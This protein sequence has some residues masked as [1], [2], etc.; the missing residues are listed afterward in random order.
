MIICVTAQGQDLDAAVDPRFGRCRYF[1]FVDP[2]TLKLE[3]IEND[4]VNAAGGAGV[5]SG[6]LVA[7]REARLVLTGNV[8]PNAHQTLKAAGVKIVTGVSGTVREAVARYSEGALKPTAG[9]S[10]G[11]HAGMSPGAG[12]GGD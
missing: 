9:A 12:K 3:A 6:Q 10:V 5:R 2:E 1:L 4:N 7:D 11:S 8:G